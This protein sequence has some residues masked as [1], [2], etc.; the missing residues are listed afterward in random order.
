MK[1]H[2]GYPI[3]TAEEASEKDDSEPSGIEKKLRGEF[4]REPGK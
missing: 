4:R 3:D 1:E 2:E